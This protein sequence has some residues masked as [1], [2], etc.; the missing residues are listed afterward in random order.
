MLHIYI[1]ADAC[2]VKEETYRVARRY[3]L[4]VTLV[5]NSWM[6]VPEAP[7]I[8]LQVVAGGFDV[9]DDWIAEHAGEDDVVVTADIELA[10]RCLKNGAHVI[11]TTGK[12]FTENN[13]GSALATRDLL[14]DL[15]GIGEMGGGP[16]PMR[17][18]DR[19]RFLQQ[20]DEVI[21]RVRR[22]RG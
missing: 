14:S 15:R 5:A 2:P 22:R 8:T 10:S 4:P 12:R 11:G 20:L 16:P 19:S 13:I 6:R 3:G 7:T 9:A 18:Q 1:D 21:Q 17:K